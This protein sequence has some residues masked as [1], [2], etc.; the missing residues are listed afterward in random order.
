M[1]PALARTDH[2]L[3][4]TLVEMLVS[5]AIVGFASAMLLTGISTTSRALE[6]LGG[7]AV[8]IDD[9]TQAQMLLRTR[10]ERLVMAPP[11]NQFFVPNDVRGTTSEVRFS[12]PAPDG[13]QPI[14]LRR[15]WL[16][17]SPLGDLTLYSAH[18][19]DD[20]VANNG[21]DGWQA[22]RLLNDVE[23]VSI[24]Y[25]GNDGEGFPKRWRTNWSPP[26]VP[27]LVRIDVSFRPGDRRSWP[28]LIIRPG[29]VGSLAC[30]T[31]DSATQ[32]ETA[33]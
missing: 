7:G 33:L 20:R 6:R 17:V 13:E 16:S 24:A 27:D 14:G 5:L 3:G 10:I 15:F 25:F 19:L 28:A 21:T 8:A 1:R 32:C 4:F 12:A 11:S 18:P 29:A 2:E 22:A 30:A 31:D 23:A 26:R 9:V